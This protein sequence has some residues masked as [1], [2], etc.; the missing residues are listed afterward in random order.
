MNDEKPNNKRK[1]NGYSSATLHAKR[2]RKRQEAEARQAEHDKLTT[3]QKLT[4]A[5]GRRERNRLVNRLKAEDLDKIKSRGNLFPMSDEIPTFQTEDEAME[6]MSDLVNDPCVDNHRFAY[7]DDIEA[8]RVFQEQSDNG[9]CG[10][11]E[12][13]IIVNGRKAWIGCNYGH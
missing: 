6:W 3:A 4:I 7:D 5:A 11:F 2:N 12:R 9:C 13:E 1:T 10:S 8:G